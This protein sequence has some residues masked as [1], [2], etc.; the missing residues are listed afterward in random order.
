MAALALT[1]SLYG[2]A[3]GMLFFYLPMAALFAAAFAGGPR[4]MAVACATALALAVWAAGPAAGL[5]IALLHSVPVLIWC[6]YFPLW[7]DGAQGREWY[8]VGNLLSL[9]TVYGCVLFL[10]IALHYA[11]MPGGLPAAIATQVT[12]GLHG[13]DAAIAEQVRRIITGWPH[14]LFAATA[15]MWLGM[16]YLNAWLA[17]NITQRHRSFERADCRLSPFTPPYA[18]LA[19]AT[20]AALMTITG[21]EVLHL[22]G[23]TWLLMLCFPYFLSGLAALHAKSAA[24]PARGWWLALIY[25]SI[26]F[27]FW[28]AVGLALWALWRQLREL[29]PA[30]PV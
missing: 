11:D 8:P 22:L 21:G 13:V 7:R 25:L 17:L 14:L 10:P 2:I 24:W 26:F 23:N 5:V 15:W 16:V 1:L 12:V 29:I 30:A 4:A 19:L 28:P 9:I 18:V 20:V 3:G 6:R 27:L